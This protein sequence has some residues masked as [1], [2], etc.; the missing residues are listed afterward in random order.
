VPD[1]IVFLGPSLPL[2]EAR[3]VLDAD[4]RPPAAHG[5]VLR[6]AL[7]QPVAIGL[8]DGV[9]DRVPSVWHKEIL[10]A[11]E[12]G[13]HVYGGA[14]IG[15]LRAAELGPYGM[16]GVGVVHGLYASGELEDDDE[17][18]VAHLGAEDGFRPTSEAMVDVRATLAAAAAAGVVSEPTAR[19]LAE[20]VKTVFYP[21]RLLAAAL[22]A[23]SP[24][25]RELAA[26]LPGGRVQQKRL[27][28]LEL[29]RT[30]R[31]DLRH[32]PAPFRPG[33]RLAQTTAWRAALAAEA[34]SP[35]PT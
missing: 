8:V 19:S 34:R 20:R 4:V 26:W 33:W 22:D 2:A 7:E 23:A 17:V 9:F 6:A 16:R 30:L 18:A 5:D 27:D 31:D 35:L 10:F 28:A 12:R 24:E 32:P 14:S 21:D 13:V 3:Q 11:L 29:L 25:E 1:A 15:A